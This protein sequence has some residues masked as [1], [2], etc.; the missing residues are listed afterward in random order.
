MHIYTQT[1]SSYESVKMIDD[2]LPVWYCSRV[3]F[4]N[5]GQV[6]NDEYPLQHCRFIDFG[7]D[8]LSSRRWKL[9]LLFMY[10]Q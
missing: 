5:G 8:M 1:R 3:V 9:L 7:M 10:M 2:P 4:L 6:R